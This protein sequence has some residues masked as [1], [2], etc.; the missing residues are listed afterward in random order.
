ML[1]W[2]IS[3]LGTLSPGSL[4][5]SN[6]VESYAVRRSMWELKMSLMDTSP[7]LPTQLCST[8]FRRVNTLWNLRESFSKLTK[9]LSISVAW[10]KGKLASLLK[11]LKLIK[12]KGI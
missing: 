11:C 3:S 5:M 8:N 9:V 12:S 6:L 2:T 1:S 10:L 4:I 7:M